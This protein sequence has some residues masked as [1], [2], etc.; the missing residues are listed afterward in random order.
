M[1]GR[2]PDSFLD[3]LV[4]RSDIVEVIGA[5][6]PL[7]K[8]GREFKACCPFHNE[9]SPSFWV[10]PAKQ[11]YHCFGCGAHG[12]VIG[13]LMQYEK[14]EFLEAVADLAQR[15]GLELPREAQAPR[16]PGTA[17]LHDV[18]ALAARFFEQNLADNSR[19]RAYVA[20][21]GIDAKTISDFALGYA[22]D[23]WDSLL[24][25]FGTHDD[26]RRRLFHVGLIVERSHGGPRAGSGESVET[27]HSGARM[28]GGESAA[29]YY[30][31]FRDRLMFP[32]RDSR[33]RVIGFGGRV[34]DQGEPKYLNSPES[35]LFHKGRELY[36]LYESRQA[37]RDFKR[38]LIVEGYMDV[39]RLHQAGIT[40]AVA[41]LG[42]ATTQEH[43]NKLFKMTSEVVFCFDGDGAG[44]RAARRAMENALALAHDGHEFRF[45][46]LPEGHDPDTLVAAEGAEGFESRLQSALPLSEYL[47]QQLSSEVDLEHDE[48]RA[49]LKDLAVPL[50]ARMP[51]GIY[52]EM[53][54]Q[55]LAKRVG[56][57]ADALRKK[58]VAA[59]D[60]ARPAAIRG[61]PAHGET[62]AQPGGRTAYGYSGTAGRPLRGTD[63]S[64][65]GAYGR[66]SA[67]RASAGRGNLLS[68]AITLV[69]HHPAAARAVRNS[70][71]LG[72]LNRAG[73]P[74]LKEL[75]EQSSAMDNP[76][77][78]MLLERWR[79]RPEYGRLTELAMAEP[80]VA[81]V[82]AAAKELQMAVEKLLEESGPGRRMD[83]LIRKAEELGLNF[84][85]KTELSLL[86]KAKGRPRAPT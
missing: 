49:R 10:S 56:M 85:E 80:M 35:P 12:T 9:K 83:E 61:L 29:G 3:D 64:R 53:V 42:T 1:A 70:E 11:F 86:L 50:F 51:D 27:V 43:L 73:I 6:V 71:A 37:R 79:D 67:G 63:G 5:R 69:V 23:A 34:I 45:M 16:D 77:T 36:G 30:D 13:F 48:G 68:Q 58:I 20:G 55:R 18:M 33:G 32:I 60:A 40:Y 26:E 44:R 38:L 41:T 39:V 15:A 22:P 82:Q 47:V 8:A 24:K 78:A 65:Q 4:V 25:R 84:D 19:A 17:D 7:K 14:M 28:N 54:L 72:S 46:F 57:P 59:T 2:I 75:L 66:A 81:E 62:L 52:R 74:V 76:T 21:R 31:R